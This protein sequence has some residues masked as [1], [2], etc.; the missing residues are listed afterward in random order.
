MAIIT[1]DKYIVYDLPSHLYIPTQALFTDRLNIDEAKLGGV[2]EA[3]IMFRDMAE[4]MLDFCVQ[5]GAN[6]DKFGL[7]KLIEYKIYQNSQDEVYDLKRAYVEYMRYAIDNQGD[8]IG[9]QSG[10]DFKNMTVLDLNDIRG[11]RELSSRLQRALSNSGLLFRGKWN[12]SVP[13]SV[14]R[15]TDY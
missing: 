11:G 13:T 8:L 4:F 15:G 6:P 12:W 9:T 1:T 2:K 3:K 7:K 14:V 5:F 10:I